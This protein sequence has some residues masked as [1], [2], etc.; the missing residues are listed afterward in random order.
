LANVSHELRTP[1]TAILG[2]TDAL[3]PGVDGPLNA[4]QETSLRW[5]QRGGQDLLGLINEILDLSKIEAGKLTLD[6]EPFDPRELVDTVVAQHRSLAAQKGIRFA[7]HDAGT[8][9][10]VVLDRQRVRQ[11][12]VN[13]IGNAL[14]FTEAG[15]VDV[16]SG[17][18]DDGGLHVAVRDTG[19]GISPELQEF[20]FE[21]FHHAEGAA[22]GS[23]LGLPISRR[24]ARAM[25]GDVT[26][27]SEPGRGSV[28]HLVLPLDCRPTP[29]SSDDLPAVA[30]HDGER[31]LLCVD[32]DPSVAHVLQK[33]VGGHG[34]RVIVSQSARTAV[35]DARR[36]QPAAIL[37]DVRLQG[38]DALARLGELKRD[39]ETSAIRVILLSAADPGELPEGVD[40]YLSKPVQQARLLRMLDDGAAAQKVQA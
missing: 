11:I 5:V 7:W 20:I 27:E 10:E 21:E 2:F 4:E 28:F 16:T 6:L 8:P 12:L 34:Y 30:A 23:G 26:F 13:L 38:R 3:L 24:L 40:G 19:P 17:A 33:M 15:D 14:K 18:T 9:T 35:E 1:M 29:A 31:V 37:I 32:D 25:G 39:A 22:A 36:D